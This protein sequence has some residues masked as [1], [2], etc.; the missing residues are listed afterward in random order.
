MVN[1]KELIK[2]EPNYPIPPGETLLETLEYLGMT[3]AELAKRT[4]RPK[5]TINE[6]IKG[7]IAIT[8]ETALQFEKV[9]GIPSSFWNNLQRNYEE[10]LAQQEENRR[11]Q[12][13]RGKALPFQ[14]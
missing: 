11:L 6:I 12:N 5:K 4:G 14:G 3:Q 10:M 9:L 7:K 2:F 1:E 8:P 13:R